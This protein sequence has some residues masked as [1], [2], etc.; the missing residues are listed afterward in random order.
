MSV[1]ELSFYTDSIVSQELFEVHRR[2]QTGLS[3]LLIVTGG[4]WKLLN[5]NCLRGEAEDVSVNKARH[6]VIPDNLPCSEV[7]SV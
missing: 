1:I 4:S 5:V 3:I 7:C 2:I 6:A